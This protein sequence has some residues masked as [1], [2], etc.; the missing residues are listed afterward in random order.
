MASFR[1]MIGLT[2]DLAEVVGSE[3]GGGRV[4][5]LRAVGAM[6]YADAVVRAGGV[7]VFLPPVPECAAEHVAM[8][9]A[10][11]LTGGDDPRTEAFG[12]PTHPKA[13][14]MNAR[15]QAYE[16]A[17]LNA[18]DQAQARS[19]PVLGVCLGMQLMSLHAGGMLNQRLEETLASH[20]EHV[21][22][23]LHEVR[24]CGSKVLCSGRVASNHRQ[25]VSDAGRL[26]V[27]A[28]AADGLIEAVEDPARPFYLGVQWHPERTPDAR[29][30]AALFQALVAAARGE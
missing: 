2:A 10:V 23:N 3:P 5:R 9:A 7:P 16:L 14:P 24:P 22:D 20:A 13:T 4:V 18:L 26:Q 11:V 15:R 1:P 21:G 29:L 25:G 30:G 27:A 8:C 17:L 28:R 19:R 12:Q 6:T